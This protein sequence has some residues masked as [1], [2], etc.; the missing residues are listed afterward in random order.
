[1]NKE[2]EKKIRELWQKSNVFQVEVDRLKKKRVV[3][4]APILVNQFGFQDGNIL[5]YLYGDSLARYLR[6]NNFNVLYSNLF[7]NLASTSF[8]EAKKKNS[9]LD[10]SF[11]LKLK[12][13]LDQI[14][15]GYD[16]HKTFDLN[17]DTSLSFIQN[18]FLTLFHKEKIQ[19]VKKELFTN[20]KKNF[21]DFEVIKLG[22]EYITW[23]GEK[24]SPCEDMVFTLSIADV[25]DAVIKQI[26][27]LPLPKEALEEALAFFQ[28]YQVMG[29]T[30]YCV[31][32]DMLDITMRN[33]EFI[34]GVSYIVLNPNL[35]KTRQFILAD[36]K[37]DIEEALLHGTSLVFTENYALNPLT[38]NLIPIF[39]SLE[40][41]EP[42]HLG[43]PD[44]DETEYAYAKK[45]DIE[46]ISVTEDGYILNSDFLTGMFIEDAHEAI[47]DSFVTEGIGIL[48]TEYERCDF[49]I[50]SLDEYGCLI[51]LIYDEGTLYPLDKNLPIKFTSKF[52]HFI[53]N[54][55]LIEASGNLIK[56]TLNHYFTNGLAPIASVLYDENIG[57]QNPFTGEA[58]KELKDFN[59][60]EYY[61]LNE[62]NVLSDLVMP[63]I[64]YHLI[65]DIT[66]K[67]LKFR[68]NNII[69][70]K[71]ILDESG[72]AFSLKNHNSLEFL[73]IEN[74]YLAD[75]IR[76][77]YLSHK[78]EESILFDENE[79]EYYQNQVY[80]LRRSW[81]HPFEKVS[82]SLEMPLFELDKSL[83]KAFL[84][85]NFK[86]CYD[87]IIT[88]Q[89]KHLSTPTWSEEQA[90][91]YLKWVAVFLPYL[92]EDV[93]QNIF[94]YKHSLLE[95]N[96]R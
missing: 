4:C 90:L 7:N 60:F 57:I 96:F 22:D 91:V 62:N 61:I 48:T 9:V 13:E 56:G 5:P 79:M 66:G 31:S 72:N 15:I 43:I 75:A 16:P 73:K 70:T 69:L 21:Q 76:L 50:S 68:I 37:N 28:P 45:H 81:N 33:P 18:F 74:K 64:F 92:G 95:E 32:G 52:R 67:K 3:Y 36:D 19:Y 25:R 12:N 29:I 59:Q 39:L 65:E 2:A 84:A 77:Y 54:S 17:G 20:K 58:L 80:A 38:G 24:V 10:T 44:I 51:P 35:M 30:F 49:I 42:I 8:T 85:C 46:F 47:I 71:N 1:M 6:M 94:G 87:L 26:N 11:V 23:Y 34:G 86:Q 40:F 53:P 93:F 55:N 82:Y 63:L 89:K 14:G 78:K 83:K 27:N 88:F 41:A